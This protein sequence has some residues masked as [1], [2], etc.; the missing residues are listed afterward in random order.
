LLTTRVRNSYDS[1]RN[2]S[3]ASTGVGSPQKLVP[4]LVAS[5]LAASVVRQRFRD[6]EPLSVGISEKRNQEQGLRLLY[7]AFATVTAG[8]LVYSQTMAFYWDEGFHILTAYLID[9]GK[10]PY[11]DF[12]FPQTPLNAYW[13]AAWMAI[14]GPS[15]RVVHLVAALATVGSVLLIAQYVFAL[16]PDRRW[17]LVAAFAALALFGLHSLAWEFGTISQAY[18]LCLLLVVAAFRAAIA[19]V[20]R[21][22]FEMS[23]LAGLAAGSAA[24][25]TLLTAAVAPVLLVWIWL[26]NRAGNRWFKAAGFVSGAAAPSIPVLI[27]F[28]HGPHQVVFDILKYH[29]VYRRVQWPGASAHDLEVV[30][31]WFNS[32]P[33]LLLA[34]LAAMGFYAIKKN[35]FDDSRYSEFRLCVWLVLAIGV[36]NL[37]A[38]PTF[39]QYFVFLIPFLTVLGV[40]GFHALVARLANPD[41]SQ[42]PLVV[43]LCLAVL[44]L[45]NTLYEDRDSPTWRQL[46][47]VAV[48]VR[49]VTRKGAPLAAPE[50]LYFLLRWPVPPG[51]EH[52]DAH[53]LKFTP[54]ENARLHIL[55]EA[56]LDEQIKGSRFP[57]AVVCDDDH[58]VNELERW[59]V[60]AQT[61][62][63]GECTVFWRLTRPPV[64]NRQ[65]APGN[66]AFALPEPGLRRGLK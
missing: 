56:E 20:A 53:K 46:E 31:D 55:P 8:L 24:A 40:I 62:A 22:R 12:F 65:P 16:F 43:L 17:R 54:E 21:P 50:Q 13:N 1:F 5:A 61:S 11:L 25:S 38:H 42:V 26:H 19:A 18:P 44:C 58:R 48:K 2:C 63:I 15:W 45:G 3:H 14:F 32:S 57:T 9:A 59:T 29:S 27:L 4:A 34:L 7:V 33:S 35:G 37:C 23:V 64:E 49:Q 52:D 28:A 6:V 51:M 47:Q 30:T 39:P 41:H 36:Q 10:R 66:P 60:Y